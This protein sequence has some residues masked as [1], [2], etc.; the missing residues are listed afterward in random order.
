MQHGKVLG[1]PSAN[2]AELRGEEMLEPRRGSAEQSNTSILF[3]SRLILKIFRRQQAGPNPD[4]EIGRY[5]TEHSG[6]R[7]I[8]PFAGSVEYQPVAPAAEESASETLAM[9][10][11]LVPNEGD[12]W[13][14]TLEDLQRYFEQVSVITMPE[15]H[16]PRAQRIA[17]RA[18]R[19]SGERLDARA[20][21]DLS[22][23]GGAAGTA[24][25]GDAPCA[26]TADAAMR[27]SLRSR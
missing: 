1:V 19:A 9:L 15:E 13:E 2:F 24:H 5:L 20:C 8:A 4:T 11:G 10:Q 23:R 26:G 12:G 25:G 21:R 7:A 14:W 22:G 27:R 16:F 17:Y 18:E 3:G 6:F